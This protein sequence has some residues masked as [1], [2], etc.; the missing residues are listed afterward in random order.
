MGFRQ[1]V[2]TLF[3]KDKDSETIGMDFSCFGITDDC[4]LKCKMCYK[5]KEDIFI[6]TQTGMPTL[7]DWKKC[8]CSLRN[9]VRDSFQ[10]NF[11]GGEPFLKEGILELVSFCKS[12]GFQTNIATNGYLI[13]ELMA[14]KITDS[15]LDSVIISLDSLNANTHDYLRGVKGVYC[16]VMDAIERLDKFCSELYKGIC[17]VIY[18]KNL[19]DIF[20]LVEWVDSDNRLNSIYFMAAMQPNNTVVDSEWYKK[21]EFSFLWPKDPRRICSIIDELI[22]FKKDGSKIINQESQLEAFKLYYRYPERFVKN[23]KC[24]MDSALHISSCGDIFL[25]YHWDL[26]G[27]IQRDDLAE[28]WYSEKAKQVRQDI[29]VCK[30]NCHSLLNC[31]F[32]GDYPFKLE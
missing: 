20:K 31:N 28:V 1:R 23:T 25:C 26:L 18:E 9:I 4:I 7:K 12:K 22:R 14:K 19:D 10:I 29:A 24:N 16:G 5:W 17:C 32:K 3:A 11:G 21:E 15:G 8:V 2:E 30:K 13:D 27:N 6:K